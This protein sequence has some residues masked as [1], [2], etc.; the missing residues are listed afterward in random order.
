M[1]VIL[2]L[3]LVCVWVDMSIGQEDRSRGMRRG[4]ERRGLRRLVRRPG[5][6]QEGRRVKKVAK[7][8]RPHDQEAASGHGKEQVV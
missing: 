8:R 2:L 7:R 4:E 6:G 5:Q 3:L 1:K